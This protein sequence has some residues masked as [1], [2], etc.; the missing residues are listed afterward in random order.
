MRIGLCLS[1]L[2]A[3][4][5][6][7]VG[8]QNES[9]IRL[10]IR[11]DPKTF[12]PL[13]AADDASETVRYITGGV[14]LRFDRATHQMRPE[15]AETWRVTDGGRRIEFVLRKGVRFSDGTPFDAAD[16]AAT[17]SRLN[18]RS[19]RSGIADTFRSAKGV[20]QIQRTGAD[21]IAL[22]FP[23]AV[24]GLESLFDQ[25]AVQSSRSPKREAAVLGP[26]VV[27]DY[28]AGQFVLLRRNQHYWKRD[29]RGGKLPYAD[30]VR[31]DILASRDIEL[32]RFRRGELDAI[33]KV[34]PDVFERLRKQMPKE[35]MDVGPSLDSEV[36]WFNQAPQAPLAAHKR[37][38]FESRV[39]RR[40]VSAA[41][42]RND[43]VRVVYRALAHPAAAY[44][45]QS[46][47]Q[48]WH[49]GL[50]PHP[51]SPA[52]ALQ[53]L[54]KEGFRLKGRQLIDRD[55]NPVQFSLITNSSSRSRTQIAAM[56]QQDLIKIGV[57]VNVVPLEFGSLIERITQ[58]SNYEAC[59]LG[60]TNVEPE[61]NTQVN[62]FLS[63]GNLHAWYPA[64][65]APATAWEAEIDQLVRKQAGAPHAVR[66]QAFDRIQEILWT[67]APVLFLVHPHVLIAVSQNLS[68][69]ASSPLPPRIY[70]NIEQIR[71]N[72]KA[73]GQ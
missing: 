15:L 34:E 50:K 52:E 27:A 71:V 23:T 9:E 20:I 73:A 32:L 47:R 48:W 14:L 53:S 72:R 4:G 42:N 44:V 33:D 41:I 68:N 61:P 69:V 59:L 19:L 3:V 6:R 64:Q 11:S 7:C 21:R 16:V 63:S 62:V 70:W 28:K 35:A 37:R 66:K 31:L 29:V 43:I 8:Q 18:D 2:L 25:L 38:W 12:D 24:A 13:L 67:E 57:Q 10:S 1:L 17:V 65:S 39:F 45:S 30:T 51:F 40:A 55:G 58:T 60:F 5:P 54:E 56:V 36:L 49:S 26:Y 22:T 46:N